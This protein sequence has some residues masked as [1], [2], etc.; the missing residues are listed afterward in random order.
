MSN[1]ITINIG[2]G[3]RVP[4]SRIV[5]IVGNDSAPT[6]RMVQDA[7]EQGRL[8]DATHG[9]RTRAVLVLDSGHILLSS[10]Q[11]DTI[12]SRMEMMNISV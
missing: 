8:I 2:F 1:N 5:A 4:V 10:I 3:N 6:K 7:R 11:P 9:R 12:A